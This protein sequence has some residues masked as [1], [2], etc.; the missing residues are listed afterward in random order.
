MFG[1][2]KENCGFRRFLLRGRENVFTETLLMGFVYDANKLHAKA[3][4]NR[5]KFLLHEK[6]IA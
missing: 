2:L 1:L 4:H 6:M 5:M 3:K